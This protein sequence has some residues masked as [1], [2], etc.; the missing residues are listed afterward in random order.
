[1][2]VNVVVPVAEGWPEEHAA[3]TTANDTKL[4]IRAGILG[5]R[6]RVFCTAPVSH[7]RLRSCRQCASHGVDALVRDPGPQAPS[8]RVQGS[9][10]ASAR[11]PWRPVRLARRVGLEPVRS[12]C[13]PAFFVLPDQHHLPN[14]ASGEVRRRRPVAR[15]ALSLVGR[16]W[17]RQCPH[18][19][20]PEGNRIPD[21]APPG[22][23][24]HDDRP[25]RHCA[26]FVANDAAASFA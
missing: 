21:S 8:S 6:S 24:V 20:A 25:R 22:L 15:Q 16:G 10:E 9:A 4:P 2:D 18:L 19:T 5:T 11:R 17:A 13:L 12:G 23:I 7:H 14:S 26:W 1:V 3:N